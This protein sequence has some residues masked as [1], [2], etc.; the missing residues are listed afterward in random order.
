ML[1]IHWGT[2]SLA[3]HGWKEPVERLMK[4]AGEK[5]VSL[6]LPQPGQ[7][8]DVTGEPYHSFWWEK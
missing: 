4:F 2:F 8:I 1:P 3:L 6:L 5:N 7:P